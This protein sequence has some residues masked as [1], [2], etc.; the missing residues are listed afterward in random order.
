MDV[1]AYES[2]STW[3]LTHD[4]EATPGEWARVFGELVS[5]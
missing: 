4:P 3:M 5:A 1:T 2:I